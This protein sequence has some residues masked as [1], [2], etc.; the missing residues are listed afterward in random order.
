[1]AKN[2]ITNNGKHLSL[3]GRL[4]TLISVSEEL[5]FL[6]GFF[7]FSGWEEL[8]KNIKVNN[9]LSL[10]ILVGLNVG[11]QLN[12][13]FEYESDESEMSSDEK[14]DSFISS[15]RKAIN[16]D[17]MDTE[18]FYSQV[19]FF[20]KMLDNGKL[21]IRK[22]KEA[23]HSKLYLFKLNDTQVSA[24]DGFI[25]GSSN[26]T[27]SGLSK[28]NEFNVEI[29]D[30]GFENAEEYF[31]DLWDSG[32][33][34]SEIPSRKTFLIEL[35]KFETQAAKVT[36]FE[37]YA[38]ILK[39]YLEL[40]EQKRLRDSVA[41]LLEK[42]GFKK[43]KYQLDSVNQALTIIEQYNGVI[44]ADVVGLGKSVV[45][46]LIAKELGKR[47]V[48]ICPPG[49][50]GDP[51][52]KESGW[53]EYL[54][55]FEL[56][57]WE[58]VSRG[59]Q[60]LE[61]YSESL[62][63]YDH[64]IDVVLIDEAHYFRNQD[65]AAY[66]A[67]LNICRGKIVIQLTATPFNNSPADIFSLLKLFIIP[68]ESSI[69]LQDNLEGTFSSYENRFKGLSNIL[70][71]YNS[72][73]DQK[74]IRAENIYMNLTGESLPVDP[75]IVRAASAELANRIK[76]VIS[77]VLI[78]R[79]R[80]DLKQ[81]FEYKEEV[82]DLSV[83]KD[84]VQLFFELSS[85]Q[86]AF[87]DSIINSYFNDDGLFRGAI[88]QP[89]TYQ[90]T[91]DEDNLNEE[92][93]RALNQQRNLFGFMRRLLV[94]R[95][96]SSF[97]AFKNSIERFLKV[98][99]VVQEF[100]KNSNGQFI[101]DRKL[102]ES[103]AGDDE[104]EI[105]EELERF[106]NDLQENRRR[107]RN[108]EV[109]IIS[110]FDRP[111]DFLRDIENDKVLFRNILSEINSLRLA[112]NDPKREVVVSKIKNIL[113]DKGEKRKIIL[114]TEYTDTVRHLKET[115]INE[116][117]G[118]V[119]ICDGT[120]NRTFETKL[121]S[122]F[123]AQLKESKQTDN[124]DIL[125]TSD[126]LSEGFNLNRAGLIINYDIPWNPTR[127]IQRV[128][129][130]N[131]IGKKVF[132]ELLIYN[133]FPTE[134]G[135]EIV[136][137]QEIAAQ[138]MFLIHTAL[139]EDSKIFSPDEEPEA[140]ELFTR[141]NQ[142]PEDLEELNL[143]TSIR[144]KYHDIKERHPEV[145]EKIKKLPARVKA[146]K[147]FPNE[148][149]VNVLR[150][151]GLGLFSLALN[152]I[153]NSTVQ[154]ISFEELLP[155]VECEFDKESK[156]LSS[157]FW[158]IYDQLKTYKPRVANRSNANAIETKARNNL[159]TAIRL[160]GPQQQELREFIQDVIRDIKNYQTLSTYTLREFTSPELSGVVSQETQEKYFDEVKRMMSRIG[161]DFLEKAVGNRKKNFVETIIAVENQ[162]S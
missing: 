160:L 145:I 157:E 27:R 58:V 89:F 149:I 38:L 132:D 47:G 78:R 156:K 138:K 82:G 26:L 8:Y 128:G 17:E 43:F 59:R 118:R 130:I 53:W 77:P 125:I 102:M 13:I 60:T 46:S 119:L 147:H 109:Y 4:N 140:S 114:F 62:Q 97:G 31:D 11:Q 161:K 25:T 137:S 42:N 111:D 150:R 74:R 133:F 91:I 21:Q 116:F 24:K 107:P 92:D 103:I 1:M 152:G 10:K 56:W 61:A 151:K 112:D 88:Y 159:Q 153:E 3:K 12:K 22:T 75:M 148:H 80:L 98:H 50:K 49:L 96:E 67:L 155:Y 158:P 154:E 122:D 95:F 121:N 99:D 83:V 117:D 94:K 84:P 131:R 136:R 127:V 44:I 2:F 30:Y 18:S 54:K 69:T 6:V 55:R 68:G 81:D 64:G 45:A 105:L 139:G 52:R 85:E 144:N 141:I 143:N 129:R 20:I 146:A 57:D 70:K 36:P 134:E 101:M 63:E 73:D 126:K 16:T 51:V 76:N 19:D 7:Y 162:N 108:N 135:S 71:N 39:T 113:T 5:K 29:L 33:P 93:N 66:E 100:I 34:I 32:L 115:F 110:E 65:T 9:Q 23:N 86:F 90:Q 41:G 104:D 120:V 48:V 123:N 87:Y 142:N 35:L 106:A 72:A 79:N 14:F 37:A 28:Q 15:I 40:Q 124:Y